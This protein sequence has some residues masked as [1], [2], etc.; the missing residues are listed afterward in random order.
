L[1][2]RHAKTLC[3]EKEDFRGWNSQQLE[4]TLVRLDNEQFE[5]KARLLREK[6]PLGVQVDLNTGVANGVLVV[7]TLTECAHVMRHILTNKLNLR[8][9]RDPNGTLRLVEER[10]QCTYRLMISDPVLTNSFWNF[11]SRR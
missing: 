11:Y 1:I 5:G 9:E 4:D 6:H 2:E 8:I 10:T 7:R 3:R